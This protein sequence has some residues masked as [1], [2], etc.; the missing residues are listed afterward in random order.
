M[1]YERVLL[2][3]R[4]GQGKTTQIMTLP[5]KKRVYGFD[6]N[7]EACLR[8]CPNM[9]FVQLL[10]GTGEADVWPRNVHQ[11]V[12]SLDR[13]KP[14]VY[15][16]FLKDV[17]KT[18]WQQYDWL[19][20]DGISFLARAMMVAVKVLQQ[21]VQSKEPRTNY[22]IVG[23]MLVDV[24][25]YLPNFPVNL[26]ATSHYKKEA[27][28][29]KP[30]LDAPGSASRELPKEFNEIWSCT[31]TPPDKPKGHPSYFIQTAP[32]EELPLCRTAIKPAPE[33]QQDVTIKDWGDFS[34]ETLSSQGIG[35]L[36][37][38]NLTLKT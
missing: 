21:R 11:N 8:R 20:V 18:D 13:V 22:Q 10:P 2:V 1:G 23:N 17:D 28:D 24:F 26:L 33:F 19:I 15:D 36:L 7:A 37:K 25:A 27:E 31:M 29:Y 32:S 30:T 16:R 5:G 34:E 9:D 6:P 12:S 14:E 38:P 35:K 3:G 4:F